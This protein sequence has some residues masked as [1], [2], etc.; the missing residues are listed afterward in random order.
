MPLSSPSL[1]DWIINDW[2]RGTVMRPPSPLIQ[3]FAEW[4]AATQRLTSRADA[5]SWLGS[6]LDMLWFDGVAIND[7]DR[8]VLLEQFGRHWG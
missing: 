5:M 2:R 4:A 8:A 6:W 3:A 7:E 1:K